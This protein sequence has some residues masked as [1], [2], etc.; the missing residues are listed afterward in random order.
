MQRLTGLF[1]LF[2]T[3]TVGQNFSERVQSIASR[4]EF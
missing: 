1:V 3:L 2:A 4:P